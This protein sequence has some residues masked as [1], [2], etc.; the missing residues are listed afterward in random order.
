MVLSL[1][2][3]ASELEGEKAKQ[4]THATMRR[5]AERGHV[6]GGTVHGYRN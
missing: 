1:R 2:S 3:F 5:R 6:T 4:R